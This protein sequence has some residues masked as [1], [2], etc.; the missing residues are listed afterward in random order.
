MKHP[1]GKLRD[2]L[3]N[4]EQGANQNTGTC[5]HWALCQ[6]G[7]HRDEQDFVAIVCRTAQPVI[8]PAPDWQRYSEPSPETRYSHP[9]P[10]QIGPLL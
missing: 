9:N 5:D 6:N 8:E 2:Q 7:D 10:I 4:R 1:S 3:T